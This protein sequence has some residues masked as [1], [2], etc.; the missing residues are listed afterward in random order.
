LPTSLRFGADINFREPPPILSSTSSGKSVLM[1]ACEKSVAANVKY[2]LGDDNLQ[3][4]TTDYNGEHALHYALR[5]QNENETVQIFEHILQEFPHLVWEGH[6]EPGPS[7]PRRTILFTAIEQSKVK[8]VEVLVRRN[9][10]N[11]NEQAESTGITA[12]HYAITLNGTIA[13]KRL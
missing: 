10:V 2:L 9:Y 12:L 5:N 1:I 7:T 6:G 8:V 3:V 4:G 11:C 13:E